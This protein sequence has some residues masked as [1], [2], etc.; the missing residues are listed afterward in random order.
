MIEIL[1]ATMMLFFVL[2]ILMTLFA[3]AGRAALIARMQSRAVN[4]ANQR[5]EW[6]RS[7]DFDDVGFL[8]PQ[9]T[10]EPAGILPASEVTTVGGTTFTVAY[11]IHW[12]DDPK[13][14]T[15]DADEAPEASRK[16][17]DYKYVVVRVSWAI[18]IPGSYQVATNIAGKESLGVP[19]IASFTT[20]T[21]P[22]RSVVSG[23]VTIG[24]K[25]EKASTG[26]AAGIAGLSLDIGGGIIY[27]SWA[28][29]PPQDMAVEYYI[30]DTNTSIT[31]DGTYEIRAIARDARGLDDYTSRFWVVNNHAPTQ[32]PVI[33]D[34]EVEEDEVEFHFTTI[35]DGQDWVST[36]V[37]GVEE[38][39]G[40]NP[41]SYLTTTV[42]V[43]NP[44]NGLGE[45]EIEELSP[46]TTYRIAL[47]GYS[48]GDYSPWSSPVTT[49]TFIDL[50][51]TDESRHGNKYDITLE[52]TPP[53]DP[54]IIV[55]HYD[56]YKDG[57]FEA[58]LN[59]NTYTDSNVPRNETHTYQV[60]AY[61]SSGVK[62]N[63]SSVIKVVADGTW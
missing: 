17:K 49:T 40:A 45:G 50:Y 36:Y 25:G 10:S 52:W 39:A 41:G 11:D 9:E 46:W 4:I 58:Q 61:D 56:L 23:T 19:P 29:S 32:T 27:Q 59:T 28:I 5:V 14:G 62:L 53:A 3:A 51:E 47:A 34:M 42:T 55:D 38:I 26:T 24:V 7:L 12:V 21:L 44:Q 1:I 6:L 48:Y 63:Q 22:D 30:W 20:D 18:P 35:Q 16:G 54:S 60:F 15:G 33:Q 43:S 31:P 2:S 8:S 13:D 57:S 37:I